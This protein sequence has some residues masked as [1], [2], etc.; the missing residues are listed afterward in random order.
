MELFLSC[1]IPRKFGHRLMFCRTKR[2]F[3]KHLL[4]HSDTFLWLKGQWGIKTTLSCW[5]WT[6][7]CAN[8]RTYYWISYGNSMLCVSEC[9]ICTKFMLCRYTW[10]ASDTFFS[11]MAAR[12]WNGFAYSCCNFSQSLGIIVI[13]EL[14]PLKEK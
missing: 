14:D 8:L 7:L 10:L 5:L 1:G 3:K 2:F 13:T 9:L 4:I 6:N 11:I 12:L